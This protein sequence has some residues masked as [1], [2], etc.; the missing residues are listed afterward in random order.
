MGK[1]T[2]KGNFSTD[3]ILFILDYLYAQGED[4]DQWLISEGI[5]TNA[6][7]N[8]ETRLS[9]T[10]LVTVWQALLKYSGDS[11][12]GLNV[13]I[14]INTVRGNILSLLALNSPTIITALEA[15]CKYHALMSGDSPQPYLKKQ[16][17]DAIFCSRIVTLPDPEIT[18]QTV[19]CMHAAIITIMR[20]MVRKEISP[21][22]MEF[23]HPKPKN[24]DVHDIFFNCPIIYDCVDNTMLFSNEVLNYRVPHADTL[25]LNTVE[26]YAQKK[27]SQLRENNSW[28]NKVQRTLIRSISTGSY[29]IASIAAEL[30]VSSRK[31]QQVLKV[32]NTNFKTILDS[33]RKEIALDHL[34]SNGLSIAELALLLGFSEQSAFN[35]AFKRWTGK[36]PGQFRVTTRPVE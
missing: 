36:T 11:N 32:E 19:E 26:Q 8:T 4:A 7:R 27:L 13:G 30:T 33:V 3:S 22:L 29:N 21:L 6:L 34:Q 15:V 23:A 25:L 35:H 28:E 14:N 2:Q 12:L 1:A 5:E 17:N 31:L 10:S 18:R 20:Q 16:V 9:A 24:S